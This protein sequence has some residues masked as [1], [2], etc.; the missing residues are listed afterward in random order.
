GLERCNRRDA[1][2]QMHLFD[3]EVG[4][5]D[6]ADLPLLLELR[7]GGPAFFKFRRVVH[8][9]MDL[10]KVNGFDPQS[11]QAVVTLAANRISLQHVMDFPLSIPAQT[12][13]G[14]DIRTRTA[15]AR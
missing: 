13:F 7:H 12:T 14:E 15:P 8:G 3:I 1:L 9:P 2:R 11:A 4:D 6:P 10:V 5:T